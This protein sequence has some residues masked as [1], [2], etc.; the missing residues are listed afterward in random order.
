MIRAD[1]N[2]GNI[3]LNIMLA[4]SLPVSRSG[5]NNLLLKC[6]PNPP[7]SSKPEEKA[8]DTPVSMLIRVK[9]GE[10]ADELMGII[11]ER[12]KLLS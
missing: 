4:T 1:T 6:V 12:K 9:T 3:L 5:K 8:D 2:L 10:D 7:I 11:D